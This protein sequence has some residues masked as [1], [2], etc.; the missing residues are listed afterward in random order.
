MCIDR[1]VAKALLAEL[2]GHGFVDVRRITVKG[3]P[4]SL[5][6]ARRAAQ[7]VAKYLT[8]SE[9]PSSPPHVKGDHRYLRPLG[10]SW[11]EVEAEGEFSDLVALAWAHLRIVTWLWYSG[12]APDWRGPSCLVLRGG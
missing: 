3:D 10:M 9:D 8:K 4:K 2:W 5:S 1:F 11:T 7:Y 6:S 12:T